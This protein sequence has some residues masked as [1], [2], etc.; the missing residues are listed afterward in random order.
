MSALKS[1]AGVMSIHVG[2]HDGRSVCVKSIFR[3]GKK[4]PQTIWT[5]EFF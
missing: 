1:K 2:L 3:S 4:I 5:A